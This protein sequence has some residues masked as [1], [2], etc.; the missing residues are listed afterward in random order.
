MGVR[1]KKV[2]LLLCCAQAVDGTGISLAH[3]KH[4]DSGSHPKPGAP[5]T[6]SA[7]EFRRH[8]PLFDALMMLVCRGSSDLDSTKEKED[9]IVLYRGSIKPD[10]VCSHI[11]WSKGPN[12]CIGLSNTTLHKATPYPRADFAKLFP[13][14]LRTTPRCKYSTTSRKH[15]TQISHAFMKNRRVGA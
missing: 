7:R 10:S 1:I 13:T 4:D 14:A 11:Y 15:W 5:Q 6:L 12:F 3:A 9:W 2:D 8:R